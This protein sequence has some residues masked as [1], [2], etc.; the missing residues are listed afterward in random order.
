MTQI[1]NSYKIY[2]AAKKFLLAFVDGLLIFGI[3]LYINFYAGTYATEIA[4]NH[5]TDIIL[6]NI[7]VFDLH[8]AFI[9][10]T[11]LLFIFILI[12]C[13]YKP[14]RFPFVLKSAALFVVIRA[15]FISLT[16]LGAF[17]ERVVLDPL[18]FIN[19]F[20]FDG[21]LFFSGHTGLPFLLALIFWDSKVL[22][23]IFI[24]ISIAFACIVL[25]AHLH[26]SIDVLSA[27]FITYS[28][29]HIA[30][31]IFKDDHEFF[32]NGIESSFFRV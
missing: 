31:K 24:T 9:Y 32:K 20:T 3:S 23:Y 17:P 27:F 8:G 7:P 13:L 19:K 12:L 14:Q 30:L 4:S 29:Y 1:I 16:H 18:S 22:R 25:L 15:V 11:W 28:I 21:D 5:V 10:G 26:Y 6:S 2:F